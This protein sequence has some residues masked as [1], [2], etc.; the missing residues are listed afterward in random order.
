MYDAEKDSVELEASTTTATTATTTTA[1]MRKRKN[2]GE[3]KQ[4]NMLACPICR[5]RYEVPLVG[6]T[7]FP[8]SYELKELILKFNE[9]KERKRKQ[10]E[11]IL[12][13]SK[14][15]SEKK[16]GECKEDATTGC[17]EC[18]ALFCEECSK[19]V[20]SINALKNHSL[21]HPDQLISSLP[22]PSTADDAS[23]AASTTTAIKERYCNIHKNQKISLYCV[24]DKEL[25]CS[26][27]LARDGGH[28]KHETITL[29]KAA[30]DLSIEIDGLISDIEKMKPT[31][32]GIK[33]KLNKKQQQNQQVILYSLFFVL[34]INTYIFL[35]VHLFTHLY[36]FIS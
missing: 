13:Q 32:D 9:E 22:S 20:H 28:T 27:C 25:V 6:V 12:Q 19:K 10:Q 16:C 8:S 35:N 36:L 11:E 33:Q 4:L 7:G 3:E 24:Q 18:K 1:T 29:E 2:A 21:V 31:L 17:V 14:T 23:D 26:H 30:D 5:G 15:L 34:L